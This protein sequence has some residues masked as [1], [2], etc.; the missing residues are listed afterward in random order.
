MTTLITGAAGYIAS[1]ATRRLLASGHHVV[2]LDD[3]SRGNIEA[4]EAI[5][6]H[7]NPGDRLVFVEGSIADGAL[8]EETIR[9]HSVTSILHFAALAYVRESVEIPLRYYE[10][11]TAGSI[12]LL[13]ACDNVG[14]VERF[15]FSS[16][17]ATYGEPPAS[18]IPI[19]EDCPQH[20]INPYGHSKL[21][22]DKM[23]TD[24]TSLRAAKARSGGLTFAAAMLRY[25]NVAGST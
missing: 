11:N 21:A 22:F 2:G 7:D 16:T 14:T 13:Q 8:I 17:C 12:A 23:L 5:R 18:L 4:I 25:F 15:V 10:N 20:P 19:T 9:E 3:L 6:A 24:Y 1:H